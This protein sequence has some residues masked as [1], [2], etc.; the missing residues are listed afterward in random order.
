MSPDPRRSEERRRDTER[1]L[2]SDIDLWLA[3][4]SADGAPY[5]VREVDELPDR[6]LIRDGAG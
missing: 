5:L 3:S 1:R 2:R 6:D 4:A